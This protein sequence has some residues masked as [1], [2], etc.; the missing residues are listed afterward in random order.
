[1]D[2]QV[3]FKNGRVAKN[4]FAVASMTNCQ[5][6]PDGTLHE[7]EVKWLVRR[8]QGGYG[9]VNT[10]GIP[11]QENGKGWEGEWGLFD[12][13]HIPGY[14][15]VCARVYVHFKNLDDILINRSCNDLC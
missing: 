7:R 10:C 13:K 14:K 2:L 11:V 6:N 4:P 1:M 15:K 8:A 12:E 5:S 9:I 3:T